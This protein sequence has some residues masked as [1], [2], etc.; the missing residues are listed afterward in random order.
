MT[1]SE[2]L[3]IISDIVEETRQQLTPDQVAGEIVCQLGGAL[4]LEP[5]VMELAATCKGVGRMAR[6]AQEA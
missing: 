4:Q 6:D 2:A 1:R 5:E 3:A